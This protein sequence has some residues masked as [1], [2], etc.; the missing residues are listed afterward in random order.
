MLDVLRK[1]NQ[2]RAQLP[3]PGV[4]ARVV[5]VDPVSVVESEIRGDRMPVYAHDGQIQ[6]AKSEH[7]LGHLPEKGAARAVPKLC[8]LGLAQFMEAEKFVQVVFQV[9]FVERAVNF[10]ARLHLRLADFSAHFALLALAEH[11]GVRLPGIWKRNHRADLLRLYGGASRRGAEKFGCW[12]S[13]GN[14]MEDQLFPR[15]GLRA[16]QVF[17]QRPPG[18]G[19]GSV[20]GEDI[21]VVRQVLAADEAHYTV[22]AESEGGDGDGRPGLGAHRADVNLARAQM[23]PPGMVPGG[24]VEGV[25]VAARL[26]ERAPLGR[27]PE[28]VFGAG[29][30]A[31]PKR[32]VAV[33]CGRHRVARSR[34]GA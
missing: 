27:E 33:G 14:A 11:T 10:E 1:E 28:D 8:L 9:F 2:A 20:A 3:L 16:V 30:Y 18:L 12:R 23:L 26:H 15:R 24:V 21:E 7:L 5:Q 17:E 13:G 25:G 32:L 19:V 31:H 4:E 34:R 22:L 29:E 6:P